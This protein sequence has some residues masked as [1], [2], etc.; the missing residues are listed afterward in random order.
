M[1]GM[2]IG[3]EEVFFDFCIL[4]NFHLAPLLVFFWSPALRAYRRI[5]RNLAVITKVFSVF[6]QVL[7]ET[8][9]AKCSRSMRIPTERGLQT[10]I[11]DMFIAGSETTASS[12]RWCVL[13]LLCHP[14]IQEKLQ[15]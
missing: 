1:Q 9:S 12:I 2:M 5:Q 14:E 8:G 7:S 11:A 13:F 3:L 6:P 15:A 4:G 10:N